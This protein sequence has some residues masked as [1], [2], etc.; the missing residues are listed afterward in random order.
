M[1]SDQKDVQAI[2]SSLVKPAFKITPIHDKNSKLPNCESKFG[3]LPYAESGDHWPTCTS[4]SQALTFICQIK[5]PDSA[6]LAALYYCVPCS[7][8]GQGKEERGEWDLKIYHSPSM[9][10]LVTLNAPN[11][12]KFA[13]TPCRVE[14][15]SVKALP[16]WEGLCSI[17]S[18]VV[19]ICTEINEDEPWEA[20]DEIVQQAGA[21][22]DY[23]TLLGGYPRFVQGEICPHCSKCNEEMSFFAQIDSEEKANLM[24][25]D[26]GS[27]YLFQCPAHKD[28]FWLEMQCY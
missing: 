12:D 25:G 9:D 3:G 18:E 23:A 7:P 28:E 8:W 11:S 5:K 16:D 17:S 27:V 10:K 22:N 13:L 1:P 2:I 19:N 15:S 26:A 21:L 20:Y 6:E 24:W 14:T 4:C